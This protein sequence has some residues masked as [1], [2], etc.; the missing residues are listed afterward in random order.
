MT[1]SN[2]DQD[3]ASIGEDGFSEERDVVGVIDPKTVLNYLPKE[4]EAAVQRWK[5]VVC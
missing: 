5:R 2:Q 3:L 1:G 4:F